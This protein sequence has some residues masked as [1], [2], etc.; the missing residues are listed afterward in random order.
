MRRSAGSPSHSSLMIYPLSNTYAYL[1]FFEKPVFVFPIDRFRIIQYFYLLINNPRKVIRMNLLSQNFFLAALRIISKSILI[2]YLFCYVI[3]FHIP[4]PYRIIRGKSN[5]II[6][7]VTGFTD[8]TAI[9]FSRIT[10]NKF[11]RVPVHFLLRLL[12]I[13]L[14]YNRW[15]SAHN[16]I[17]R[18]DDRNDQRL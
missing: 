17:V 12:A 1:P 16:L 5:H 13:L 14:F 15:Q 3:C 11:W 18:V 6:I 9:L 2:P 7:S 8:S 10:I 4:I